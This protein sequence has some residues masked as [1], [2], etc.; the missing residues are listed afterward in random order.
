MKKIVECVPNFSEGRDLE[1]IA[2]IVQ[3]IKEVAEI[4]LID[5]SSNKDHNRTVI[6]FVGGSQE[7]KEAAFKAIAKA[8]EVIDMRYHRGEHPRIGACDVCPF[9][10]IRNVTMKDCVVLA[11]ELGQEVGEK[12]GIPVYLY[13]EAATRPERKNLTDIREGE[14]EGLK[15]KLRD[16]LWK[17]DFG[18]AVFNEKSGAIVIGARMFLI[19]FN[20]NLKTSDKEIASKISSLIRESGWL[21]TLSSGRK[22]RIPGIF[23]AVKAIGVLLK[24]QEIAQVSM[25]LVNYKIT[26]IHTVYEMIKKL[27]ELAKTEVLGSEIVGLVPKE[28][29]L[30]AGRF[31]IPEEKSEEKLIQA[32]IKNLKLNQLGE[33]IPEKKIIE[34]LI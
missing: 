7:V 10:P 25:N 13:E 20:V 18:P 9:V 32:A 29:I 11:R 14:Y 5:V 3:A 31:Y 17:P 19:A 21:L 30:D 16:P 23:K 33:F 34:Y 22:I 8:T 24:E 26:P 15:E 28:A 27:A 6:T 4:K 2:Q 12:L 1:K